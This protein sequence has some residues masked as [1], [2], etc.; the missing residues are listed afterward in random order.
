[1]FGYI[2]LMSLSCHSNFSSISSGQLQSWVC[3]WGGDSVFFF[4]SHIYIYIY[5]YIYYSDATLQL[6]L[7]I[8]VLLLFCLLNSY[9]QHKFV[10][11]CIFYYCNYNEQ[12]VLWLSSCDMVSFIHSYLWP[13]FFYFFPFLEIHKCSF[14]FPLHRDSKR[15]HLF[16]KN[17]ALFKVSPTYCCHYIK[18]I[19]FYKLKKWENWSM[20]QNENS[21]NKKISWCEIRMLI[22]GGFWRGI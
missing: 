2:P 10:W 4:F 11:I 12:T 17:F 20:K 1:M 14:L 19:C 7:I 13:V 6:Y 9:N 3:V 21:Q 8:I 16:A 18:L 5:I 22:I 15:I